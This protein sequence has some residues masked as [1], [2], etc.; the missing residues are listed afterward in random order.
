MYAITRLVQQELAKRNWRKSTLVAAM[1]YKNI[2]RGMKRL[3]NCLNA[4]DCSNADL[5]SRLRQ[6]L[7]ITEA[8]FDDA[9][10]ATRRERLEES[11]ASAA[12]EEENRRARFHPYIYVRT[13]EHRP[14]SITAAAVIGPRLKYLQLN[15]TV[16]SL[17]RPDLIARVADIVKD[18]YQRNLGKCLLFGR[19]TGYALRIA[20]DETVV[21][22]T[23]GSFIRERQ[24]WME[25]E[26]QARLKVGNHVL[27]D[28]LFGVGRQ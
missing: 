20:Y 14:A 9:V 28:G 10:A 3:E 13:S 18:H 11:R 23:D 17:P 22:N 19:I 1:G 16:L 27:H 8:Q 15:D 4:G 2:S 24:G 25:D 21:F 12:R 6:A 26:G 7:E 5:L